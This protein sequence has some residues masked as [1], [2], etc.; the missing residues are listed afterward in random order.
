MRDSLSL[1]SGGVEGRG[2]YFFPAALASARAAPSDLMWASRV[3]ALAAYSVL[4]QVLR[5]EVSVDLELGGADMAAV[6]GRAGEGKEVVVG[7]KAFPLRRAYSG[8]HFHVCLGTKD[9]ELRRC[10]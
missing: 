6:W 3:A 7:W 5:K 4:S 1:A 9:Y 2:K 10:M 8:S